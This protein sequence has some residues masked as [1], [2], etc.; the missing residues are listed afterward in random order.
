MPTSRIAA[1]CLTRA[2]PLATFNTKDYID[3]AEHDELTLFS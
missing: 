3:F 1:C 2:L